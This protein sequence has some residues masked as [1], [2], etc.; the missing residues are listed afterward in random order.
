[1]GALPSHCSAL[2]YGT[3]QHWPHSAL[4]THLDGLKGEH[5]VLP[6]IEDLQDGSRD[7]QTHLVPIDLPI[8]ERQGSGTR[9]EL[10]SSPHL[11][12]LG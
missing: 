3:V 9:S 4:Q 11:Y 10:L 2:P 6:G 12:R 8:E 7:A 1:M 5:A